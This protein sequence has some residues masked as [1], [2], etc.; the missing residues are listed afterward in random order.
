[1]LKK[2]EILPMPIFLFKKMKLAFW[3]LKK[4]REIPSL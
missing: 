1:M 4:W 3:K 2:I